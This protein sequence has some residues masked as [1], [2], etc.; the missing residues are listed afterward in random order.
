MPY[1]ITAAERGVFVSLPTEDD[2]GR[3]IED[4]WRRRD[5]DP[6]TPQNEYKLEYARRVALADKRFGTGGLS[7][8]RTDRGKILILLGPPNDIQRDMNPSGSAGALA[9]LFQGPKESWQYWGLPNPK[10]PYNLEFVFVD[11]AGTGNYVLEN[12]LNA[13]PGRNRPFDPADLTFRFDRMEYLAEAQKNPF[14]GLA[15]LKEIITTQVSYT[16]IPVQ[17][18]AFALK[19]SG[20]KALVPVTVLFPLDSVETKRGEGRTLHSLS[21]VLN[22]SD[23]LGRIVLEKSRDVS[24]ED[25]ASSDGS[26]RLQTSV[27]LEP[28]PYVVHI[29]LQDNFSGKVGTVHRDIA[30]PDFNA[31]GLAVSAVILSSHAG[32]GPPGGEE[33]VGPERERLLAGADRIFLSGEELTVY[34]EAYG[35]ALDPASGLNGFRVEYALVQAGAV[36]ARIAAPFSSPAAQQDCRIETSF[37]LRNFRPGAYVLR[38][39]VTDLVSGRSGSQ[40]APLTIAEAPLRER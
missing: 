17:A 31:G 2:R 23:A 14:E 40:E 39:A 19:G 29:L 21:L 22:V 11:R 27:L 7:G 20:G 33:A 5:P 9:S 3:F 34:C 37:K 6:K 8:W 28:G 12:S 35:L 25:A 26:F 15:R 1:I 18:E 10:L 32:S 13:E 24:L 30:V 38:V 16:S 4:F 36:V